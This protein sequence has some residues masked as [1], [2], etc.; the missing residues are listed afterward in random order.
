[1]LIVRSSQLKLLVPRLQEQFIKRIGSC[2][3]ALW[4][5]QTTQLGGS[6]QSFLLASIERARS[7]GIQTEGAIA[8]FINL[9]FVWGPCF[10]NRPEHAWAA[11]ILRNP[12]FD[13]TQKVNELVRRTKL[14]LR[15]QELNKGTTNV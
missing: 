13:G 11:K 10:E 1:M 3:A 7:F 15:F 2:Y 5:A 8:R 14:R 6:Y 9:Y 4:P 12:A